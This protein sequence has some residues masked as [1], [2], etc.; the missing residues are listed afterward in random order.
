MMMMMTSLMM[1]SNGDY[2]I[3]NLDNNTYSTLNQASAYLNG[4][5]YVCEPPS[6]TDQPQQDVDRRRTSQESP[7]VS[8]GVDWRYGEDR[9]P[10]EQTIRVQQQ[11]SYYGDHCR[12]V[13]QQNSRPP[14]G[15][16]HAPCG[17]SR[18]PCGPSH[19]DLYGRQPFDSRALHLRPS[20]MYGMYQPSEPPSAPP[21]PLL[22]QELS[23]YGAYPGYGMGAQDDVNH[24]PPGGATPISPLQP[25]PCYGDRTIGQCVPGL[26]SSF[27]NYHSTASLCLPPS[28]LGNP[29]MGSGGSPGLSSSDLGQGSGS[30][31][32]TYKWM[33]VKRGT[34]RLTGK[35]FV[36][37][38]VPGVHNRV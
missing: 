18:A 21:P 7:H 11:P 3:C 19:A 22:H 29:C 10:T 9:M 17:P 20:D 16:S 38:D 25:Y 1:Q 26:F 35:N 8:G 14:C 34:P 12:T 37:G 4:G 15:P 36:H 2:T 24:C 32:A 27:S 33:T 5:D 6:Y 30:G 13:L 28:T 23:G 31:V